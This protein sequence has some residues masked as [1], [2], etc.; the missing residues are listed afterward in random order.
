MERRR[1]EAPNYSQYMKDK[2]QLEKQ[3]KAEGAKIIGEYIISLSNIC[4]DSCVNTDVI[5]ISKKEENCLHNCLKKFSESYSYT[6]NKM[7][8]VYKNVDL[9]PGLD[10]VDWDTFVY[11]LTPKVFK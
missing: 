9:S 2:M 7:N 3:H 6:Y 8:N 1:I 11:K 10:Y 4:F 5:Y